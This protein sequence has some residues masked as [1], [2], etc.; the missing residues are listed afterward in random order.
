VRRAALLLLVLTA[1]ASAAEEP[2]EKLVLGLSDPRRAATCY[3]ELL[4][5]KDPKAIPLLKNALPFADPN[6]QHYGVL[7]LGTYRTKAA[8]DALASLVERKDPYLRVLAGA[9]LY[10]LG[11]RSAVPAIAEAI[12]HPGVEPTVRYLM[13]VR[14]W[15]V[16]E[17]EIRAAIAELLVPKGNPAVLGGALYA[18]LLL[19]ARKESV[20][21]A[22]LLADERLAIRAQAAA[23]LFRFGREAHAD[24]VAEGVRMPFAAGDW[25]RVYGYLATAGRC[26]PVILG[27]IADRVRVEK[28]PTVAEQLLVLLKRYPHLPAAGAIESRLADKSERIV[29]AAYGALAATPGA[30]N[31]KRLA[32]LIRHE[33]PLVRLLAA[34]TLRQEDDHSGLPAVIALVA[35]GTP[36]E[37]LEAARILCG[38]VESGAVDPLIGALLDADPSV[39]ARALASLTFVLGRLFP[40]R[41]FQPARAGYDPAKGPDENRAAV[42]RI[43]GW[44]GEHRADDW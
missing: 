37:R 14:S 15:R 44:G 10:R 33:K 21:A 34:E 6:G 2:L 39:R 28:D 19:E 18:M 42:E 38:F 25:A 8:H 22:R 7:I 1:T 17:P 23:L 29:R 16:M 9:A 13:I 26:S 11:D 3:R 40:Y 35:K 27:A 12:L 20:A 30:L 41:R 4:R 43:G 5:R 24:V 32:A 31:A 36:T